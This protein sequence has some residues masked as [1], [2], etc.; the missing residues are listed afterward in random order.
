MTTWGHA[1]M[2]L[3]MAGSCRVLRC[4]GIRNGA[5]AALNQSSRSPKARLGRHNKDQHRLIGSA[6]VQLRFEKLCQHAIKMSCICKSYEMRLIMM[7]TT[8]HDERR[9]RTAPKAD[10][11]QN[12]CL[13]VPM[14]H[15]QLCLQ[16]QHVQ[17]ST[18]DPVSSCEQPRH[19]PAPTLKKGQHRVARNR[20]LRVASA[21]PV[22]TV[23]Q[24]PLAPSPT[25]PA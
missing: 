9:S 14:Q 4:G 20:H 23:W 16:S 2:L 12:S 15:Y 11:Y 8:R 5:T 6:A 10:C 7:D 25:H 3:V 18:P 22:V 24:P 13:S 1:R 19:P 21:A 17:C